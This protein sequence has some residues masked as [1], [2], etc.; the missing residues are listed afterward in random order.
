[1]SRDDVP[2]PAPGTIAGR[3]PQ[4]RWLL[5]ATALGTSMAFLDGTVV[6]IALRVLGDDLDAS[7]TELQWV[8]NAYLLTLSSL[9]LVGG[10][11]ADRLGRRRVY[12]VGVVGFALASLACG[13]APTPLTL[14]VARLVQGAF[15]ALLT[16]GSLALIQ[17]SLVPADRARAIGTWSGLTSIS[18]LAGPLVG[19]WLIDVASWR[20]IFL[21]NLPLAAVVV[22]L[23]LRHVPESRREPAPGEDRD[24]HFDV[25]GAATSALALAGLTYALTEAANAPPPLLAAAVAL[26]ALGAVA[27][28]VRERRT[29]APLVP[30]R[31]FADR[32]FSAASAMTLLVYGALGAT[33]FFLTLQLQV[34]VGM[35]PLQAGLATLP[36]T[37]LLIAFS[38]RAGALAGR[39]GPRVPLSLGP[40]LCGAGTLLLAGVGQG[41]AYVSGVLPG[42]LLFGTGLTLLVAPLTA[43]VLAAAPDR[44]AG[45]ASGINNAIAR[46]GGLLAV[47]ALPAAVGL[48]GTDYQDPAAFTAGYAAA[49]VACA[50]LLLLGGLV[51]W[52]GLGSRR[53]GLPQ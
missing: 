23:C 19:G 35:S 53:E 8:V 29:P 22:A 1:M 42:V 24:L 17:A 11:L 14:I 44:H 50:V 26:A 10:S 9:I 15:A 36:M 51:S 5:A 41:T 25:P 3:S 7:L 32:V 4:G 18:I 12:L 40:V 52:V 31:L 30:F 16:P 45:V 21:I 2:G 34:S 38:G 46:T 28:V 27:F 20:W 6:T 37:L 43:T 47:A 33:S 39:V 48:G 13:L 49:Q